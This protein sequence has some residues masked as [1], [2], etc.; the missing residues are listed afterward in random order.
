M[1]AV[2][3]AMLGDEEIEAEGIPAAGLVAGEGDGLSA[4]VSADKENPEGAGALDGTD[5]MPGLV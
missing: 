2:V 3:G 1:P 5:A 4:G